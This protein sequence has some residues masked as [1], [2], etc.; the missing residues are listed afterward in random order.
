[1]EQS[2]DI[3]NNILLDASFLFGGEDYLTNLNDI[4]FSHGKLYHGNLYHTQ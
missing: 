3:L 1:M 4:S 2:D